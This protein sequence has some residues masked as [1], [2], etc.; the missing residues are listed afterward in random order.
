MNTLVKRTTFVH[1]ILCLVLVMLSGCSGEAK[2]ELV[3]VTG[4]VVM[5][6]KPL[7]AGSINFFPDSSNSY[8]KDNPSSL[9]QIDGTFTMK[10][11]PFGDGVAPGVYKVTLAP[12]LA[13][14]VKRPIYGKPDTTPWS[15][16]VPK[17]GI[18]DHT[19][20]VK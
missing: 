18:T 8:T 3:R 11:F 5:D 7:T 6:G 10:T 20:E 15:I 12:E 9:L 14:R 13:S 4:K 19:F 2:P 17:S 16:E 1:Q